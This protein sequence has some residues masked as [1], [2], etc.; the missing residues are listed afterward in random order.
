MWLV[1]LQEEAMKKKSPI[2]LNL[3]I[4]VKEAR[5]LMGAD[6]ENLSD[7][8]METIIFNLTELA[9]ELLKGLKRDK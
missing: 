6:A 4:S 5:K 9:Q 1:V 8:E 2:H 7:E 3:I